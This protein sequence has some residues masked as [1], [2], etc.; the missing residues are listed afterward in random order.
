MAPTP[1]SARAR[2]PYKTRGRPRGSRTR[3]GFATPTTTTRVRSGGS[4]QR[5]NRFGGV[6]GGSSGAS[7]NQQDGGGDK[8]REERSYLEFHPDFDI[9]LRLRVYDSKEIDGLLLNDTTAASSSNIET[10]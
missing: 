9:N 7:G 10:G 4:T 2:G 8:P 3:L 1:S 6:G 5:S